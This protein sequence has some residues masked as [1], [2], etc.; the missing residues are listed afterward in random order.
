MKKVILFFCSITM[1]AHLPLS[2]SAQE[3]AAQME[4]KHNAEANA[5]AMDK[6][7]AESMA[8]PSTPAKVTVVFTEFEGTKKIKSL[9]FVLY[10]NAP[11]TAH[12]QPGWSK[13]RIGSRVPIYT[14]ANSYNYHDVG[15]NLDVRAARSTDDRFALELNL[16]R[17]WVDG[18]T[19]APTESGSAPAI[20]PVTSSSRQPIVR[21][22]K[23]ELSLSLRDGQSVE[24]VMATDAVT[25]KVLRVEVTLNVAK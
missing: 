8:L 12:L 18:E 23:S 20:D 2:V 14:S 4:E 10:V 6:S 5:T 25:G 15:T 13:I 9:P 24:S 11:H 16:E 1:L 17:S 22:F 21:Q 19:P 7:K 3:S